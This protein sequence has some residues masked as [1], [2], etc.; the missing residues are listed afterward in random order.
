[1]YDD[2]G[3]FSFLEEIKIKL[4]GRKS[5]SEHQKNILIKLSQESSKNYYRDAEKKWEI[6]RVGK[7]ITNNIGDFLILIIFRNN[8]EHKHKIPSSEWDY[9]WEKSAE[10]LKKDRESV[11]I[12]D[13]SSW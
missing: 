11:G 7:L 10:L 1:M 9:F 8:L 2:K 3:D 12:T 5:I 4:S 13:N 6:N